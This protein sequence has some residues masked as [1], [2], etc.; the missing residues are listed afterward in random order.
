[1]L[2]SS[3]TREIKFT[4]MWKAHGGPN[5]WNLTSFSGRDQNKHF[6]Y[7][8]DFLAIFFFCKDQNQENTTNTVQS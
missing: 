5:R 6:T 4:L 3:H 1:M 8:G 2:L 7:H